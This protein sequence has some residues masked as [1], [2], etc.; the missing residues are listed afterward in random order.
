M[1]EALLAAFVAFTVTFVGLRLV[2]AGY[3]LVRRSPDWSPHWGS[4]LFAV[5]VGIYTF[6]MYYGR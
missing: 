1:L 6:V 2:E 3:H 4:W 5:L